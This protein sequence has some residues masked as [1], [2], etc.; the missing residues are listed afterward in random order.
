MLG[1]IFYK[2]QLNWFVVLFKS[3]ASLL[4]FLFLYLMLYALWGFLLC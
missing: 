4:I 1:V 3:S 2:R